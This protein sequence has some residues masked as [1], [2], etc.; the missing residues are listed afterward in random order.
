M[1]THDPIA[2]TDM[3]IHAAP[4]AA[5]EAFRD[6]AQIT[7]FWPSRCSGP[8]DP[9]ARVAFEFMVP[10]ATAIDA[11]AGFSQVLCEL[12]LLLEA[13]KPGG[14]VRDKAALIATCDA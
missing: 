10:G 11:T 13:G 2:T 8:L 12:K 1:R 7:R 9:G 6:P 14:M 5:F 4:H 3:L